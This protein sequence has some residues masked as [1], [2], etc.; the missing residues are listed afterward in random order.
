M[1][2]RQRVNHRAFG[3]LRALSVIPAAAAV[4]LLA[5]ASPAAASTAPYTWDP[6]EGIST[7]QVIGTFVGIPLLLVAVIW[8]F[9]LATARNNHVPPPPSTE[10]EQAGRQ[11]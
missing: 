4:V 2:E 7:L 11:H 8:V 10:V 3:I 6:G 5:V 9:A 1:S